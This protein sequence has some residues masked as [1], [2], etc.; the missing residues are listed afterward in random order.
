LQNYLLEPGNAPNLSIGEGSG[1]RQK[2]KG[3]RPKRFF[4]PL[5]SDT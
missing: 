4:T 3:K 2:V 5:V 1:K